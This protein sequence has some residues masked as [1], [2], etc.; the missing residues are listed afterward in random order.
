[1]KTLFGGLI[2]FENELKLTEF[3]KKMD[4]EMSLKIIE[5]ALE[6]GMKN[7]LFD[8]AEACCIYEA[9]RKIKYEEE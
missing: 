2:E 7:G 6:Y 1:M 8:L 9:L 3:L 5:G 4:N